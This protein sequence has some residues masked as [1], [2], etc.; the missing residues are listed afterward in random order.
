MLRSEIDERRCDN[1]HCPLY[2]STKKPVWDY[3][4]PETCE[5]LFIAEAPGADEEIKGRPLVG[6]AGGVFFQALHHAG[7]TRLGE[8]FHSYVYTAH[9]N[10]D[11]VDRIG[12][13]NICHCRPPGNRAP[14]PAEARECSKYLAETISSCSKLKC[15]VTMGD[16]PLYHLLGERSITKR[17]GMPTT[18]NGILCLPTVH[19]ASCLPFRSPENFD[20]LCK[21]F[22]KAVR[23]SETGW[24]Y[25]EIEVE[26]ITPE[27]VEE[28]KK[29]G[30]AFDIETTDLSI[31]NGRILGIAF[32]NHP[33]KAYH[34][35]RNNLT[36][37]VLAKELLEA[38]C[39][40]VAQGN[41][42]DVPFLNADGIRIENVDFDTQY[43][44]KLIDPDLPATLAHI[45]SL[46]TD[47]P[48][49][50]GQ[51][52][53]LLAGKLSTRERKEYCGRDAAVTWE[54]VPHLK[55]GLKEHDLE[56]VFYE[57]I[58]PSSRTANRMQIK[59]VKIDV[60]RRAE[61]EAE[62]S[63]NVGEWRELFE[64]Y[65]YN[66]DSPVQLRELLSK[67]GIRV[68]STDKKHLERAYHRYMHPIIQ[69]LLDYRPWKKMEAML[70]GKEGDKGLF[71][72]VDAN[73]IIHTR[74]KP[75]GT[76]N[77]RWSSSNP[78]LQNIPKE[79]RHIFIP[80][81][82]HLNFMQADYT[83]LEL[84]VAANLSGDAE[85]LHD[86]ETTNIH[87]QLAVEFYGPNYT[88]KQKLIAKAL[89]FGTIYGRSARSVAMEFGITI[90]E[91]EKLQH[92][93]AGRYPR[94][95]NFALRNLRQIKSQG[96]L[97]SVF[98]RHRYFL[99]GN[100]ESDAANY[101]VQT[102]AGDVNN[103]S[104]ILID[105]AGL[106]IRLAVHDSCVIQY[107]RG[108]EDAYAQKLIE[109][110][111][112]PIPEI[113]NYRFPVKIEYG[114]NWRDLEEWHG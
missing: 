25:P 48:Y 105:K 94:L 78:N 1:T 111:S 18:F 12:I 81:E 69:L 17:R 104:A 54:V 92:R 91:A 68:A 109:I 49:Y 55:A 33:S 2:N 8:P 63:K 30:Y 96:Y 41:S 51:R 24:T 50:K 106:D 47:Q 85:F 99:S 36:E 43:A 13:A 52:D 58:M 64:S 45:A 73:G 59:G 90:A 42:F 66:I 107:P 70:F 7:L 31:A 15:I 76:A 71:A 16:T 110:M 97:R 79:L 86:V 84:H 21:D 61:L 10:L 83:R 103:V 89:I 77:S 23:L 29:T 101:P 112:R 100:I 98:G 87:D 46:Y 32:S 9:M 53:E 37:W 26:D 38:D 56:K 60:S 74:F 20:L 93:I 5:I 34:A 40:K 27:A 88:P 44:Q 35:E 102:A 6:P 75:N 22:V 28:L 14:T 65:G 3:Y 57:I 62:I 39:Y 80:S 72:Q 67:L 113:N 4:D 108:E 95:V 114:P 11:P 19:P 82:P